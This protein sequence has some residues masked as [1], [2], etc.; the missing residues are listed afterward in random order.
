MKQT[1][2]IAGVLGLS[3]AGAAMLASATAI[4]AVQHAQA[5][6]AAAHGERSARGGPHARRT[7]AVQERFPIDLS[8]V[9][10]RATALFDQVDAAGDGMITLEEFIAA[11]LPRQGMREPGVMSPRMG[12]PGFSGESPQGRAGPRR[13][14]TEASDERRASWQQARE[15]R[16]AERQAELF[17]AADRDGDGMLSQSEFESLTDVRREL[18]RTQMFERLDRNGDGVLDRNEFPPGFA[19]LQAMDQDR[20]G[21]VTYAEMREYRSAMRQ[22]R[23]TRSDR[24]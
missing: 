14:R 11:E 22:Q 6:A 4:A 19:E 10:E 17:E 20:D 12:R 13:D 3:L 18:A 24:R 23:G 7:A 15:A 9:E 21:V 2:L 5:E 1:Y 16:S 8:V